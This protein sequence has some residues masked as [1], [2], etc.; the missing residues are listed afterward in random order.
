[1]ATMLAGGVAHADLPG[2]MTV[3]FD[4]L[5][6]HE[7]G[8]DLAPPTNEAEATWQYFNYAHCKC[9]VANRD[10]DT[11]P[12][13]SFAWELKPVAGTGEPVNVPAEIWTGAECDDDTLRPMNCVKLTYAT[14]SSLAT[15]QQNNIATVEINLFDLMTPEPDA[16]SGC[17]MRTQTATTWLIADGDQ[18][19]SPDYFASRSI[20]TDT[21]APPIPTSFTAAGAENA[22]D[23]TWS[24]PEGDT[25]DIFAYQALCATAEGE[26][27]VIENRP[28][29]RYVTARDL[30]D[31][32]SDIEIKP[33]GIDTGDLGD[34]GTNAALATGLANLESEYLCGETTASTATNLR[35]TGLQNGTS[36]QV[37]LV[38]VDKFGN[39][40]GTFFTS[41][42]TPT[43]ATDFWEDLH[44]QGSEVEGGFCLMAETYGDDNFLTRTLRAF[45]DDTLADS[46]FGRWL[47][48]VYYATLGKLG[49]GVHG[50]LPL[51]IV[52][53][54][55]LAPLVVLALGWHYLTLPGLLA[56]LALVVIARRNRRRILGTRMVQ[57]AA[58]T[59]VLLLALAPGVA[60]ADDGG[61]YD[62][63]WNDPGNGSTQFAEDERWV[64]WHVGVRVGPYTPEI[65]DQLGGMAPGPYKQMFGGYSIVPMLDIDRILW[66]GFGQ[67]GI[68]GNIGFMSKKERAWLDGSDPAD[69]DRPRAMGD[70]NKFRLIPL[71][72]SAVYRFSYLDDVYGIPIVPY[73]KAGL[74]YYIWWVDAPNGDFAYTCKSGT[75][76][77]CDKNT[78]AGASLGFQGSIGLAIRAERIDK[79]AANSMHESGIEHAGFYAELSMAKVNGFGDSSKL[80]VGD[81][82]WFA[83]VDFEF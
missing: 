28:S 40:R 49:S 7:D 31:V 17:E 75:G 44:D 30:C 56:L 66:R 45:R 57:A 21:L 36:Y 79:G 62:P 65:D 52:A 34:G 46:A 69:P 38:A 74:A 3:T 37:V 80:S 47:T 33:V 73:V 32:T 72:L 9:A 19:G 2:G 8:G 58:T 41:L 22:I 43:P 51:R 14:I 15:L 83:G 25:T 35:I 24:L 78:A 71:A 1:M 16:T 27:A 55:L 10:S 82:T 77:S 68:G 81:T 59:V 63:Y 76:P 42:L 6:I 23:I 50:S 18:N 60:H 12:E 48:G 5:L 4:R 53:G 70:E 11:Y 39:A 26:A 61:G 54:I 64:K 13:K 20:E 29:P 67:L